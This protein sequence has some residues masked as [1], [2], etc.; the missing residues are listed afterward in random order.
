MYKNTS[1]NS[2]HHTVSRVVNSRSN[3][4]GIDPDVGKDDA[5]IKRLELVNKKQDLELR[6]GRMSVQIRI[7]KDRN[8][9]SAIDR[10]DFVTFQRMEQQR[11]NMIGE[12][13]DIDKALTKLKLQKRV[14]RRPDELAGAFMHMAKL[15]LAEPVFHRIMIEA[16]HRTGSKE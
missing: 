15:M 10:V 11:A 7:A 3:T 9:R 2:Q 13:R 6:V 1:R 8:Y 16:M 12:I 5:E 4:G 14:D